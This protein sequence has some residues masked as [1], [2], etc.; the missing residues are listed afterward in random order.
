MADKKVDRSMRGGQAGA[1]TPAQ[2]FEASRSKHG[3]PNM[4]DVA[5]DSEK[6]AVLEKFREREERFRR[7]QALHAQAENHVAAEPGSEAAAKSDSPS[8]GEEPAPED[9]TAD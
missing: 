7:D 6:S 1:M 4:S 3:T 5:R 9:D 2:V 8:H